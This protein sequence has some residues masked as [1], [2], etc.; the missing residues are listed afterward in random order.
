MQGPDPLD[1]YFSWVT[2]RSLEQAGAYVIPAHYDD[3]ALAPDRDRFN[4]GV[5]R[6]I[7]G[8]IVHHEPDRV[9]LVGKSRGTNALALACSEDLGLP[10]DTRMIWQTPVWR[11][12][13]AWQAACANTIPSLHLV[14]LADEE[15]HLPERHA[16]VKGGTVAIEG[17]GHGLTIRGDIIA[18]LDALR[19]MAEAIIRFAS[20][21]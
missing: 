2:L 10:A 8:A 7:R 17:G 19:T 3:D 14:G 9:T 21:A 18:S 4:A 15:Y 5:R 6:A 12:N 13:Y 16:A 11:G 1:T 20:R